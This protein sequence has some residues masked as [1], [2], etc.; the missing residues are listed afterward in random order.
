MKLRHKAGKLELQATDPATGKT[1]PVAASDYLTD[2]QMFYC[3]SHP[4][5]ILQLCHHI[6][7]EWRAEHYT[8]LEVRALA[9]ASLNGRPMATLIDPA[10]DLAAQ[11]RSLKHASWIKP[12]TI[13][14]KSS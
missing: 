9:K 4:E 8:P 11:P 12:L 6:A 10:V 13:P 7:K 1:W 3:A 14:L 5:M 2:D